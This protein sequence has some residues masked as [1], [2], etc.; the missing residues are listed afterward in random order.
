MKKIFETFLNK[1]G[2]EKITIVV[3]IGVLL[4]VI[5]IPTEKKST[6]VKDNAFGGSINDSACDGDT[7]LYENYIEKKLESALGKVD[8]VGSVKAVVTLKT[9]GEKVLAKDSER[10]GS[11]TSESDD[12]GSVRNQ[13]TYNT[14][15]TH[16]LV[17][18]GNVPYVTLQNMPEIEGVVIVAKG[19]GDGNVATEITQAVEALLG[20]PAHKIKVLKMS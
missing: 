17:E 16:I 13:S 10:S 19:G 15:D 5:M 12:D 11:D 6:Q 18:D 14:S 2:K 9:S 20:I 7:F 4:L 1:S 3:L 8:G